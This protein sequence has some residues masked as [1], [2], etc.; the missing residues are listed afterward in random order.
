MRLP[1]AR[2]DQLVESRIYNSRGAESNPAPRGSFSQLQKSALICYFLI[3]YISLAGL[4]I[5]CGEAFKDVTQVENIQNEF[6]TNL[7]NFTLVSPS[8]M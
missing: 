7:L 2:L 8:T 4:V 1:A 6:K 3:V 5:L